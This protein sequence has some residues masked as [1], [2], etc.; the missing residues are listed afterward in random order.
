MNRDL[1]VAAL[2]RTKPSAS[3]P[4][5]LVGALVAGLLV[6]AT[7]APPALAQSAP[8]AGEYV[9][10][11]P[12]RLLDSRAAG[13]GGA[14]AALTSRDIQVTG[15]GGVPTT[16]VL[17]VVVNLAAFNNTADGWGL[18]WPT[19]ATRPN[20]ASNI[21]YIAGR[22]VNNAATVKLG[23][24]GKI[25]YYT[26]VATDVTVDVVGYYRSSPGAGGYVGVT[27]TRVL[28]TRYTGV[29]IAAG[30]TLDRKLRGVAA[31][32]DSAA[33]TAVALNMS[34][35]SQEAPGWVTVF[36]RGQAL[37]NTS[38]MNFV[39]GRIQTQLV[40]ATLS[41]DG[42]ASFYAAA[43]TDMV[44][45]V[46]GYYIEGSGA[47]F[48]PLTPTRIVDTRYG[49][50]GWGI[51]PITAALAPNTNTAIKLTGMGGVPE[52]GV[53]TVVINA[54]ADT[55]GSTIGQLSF[56]AS[57]DVQPT[58]T[59]SLTYYPNE[60]T[61]N[62][63]MAKV[64]S[65][66]KAVITN[67]AGTTAL[68]LDVVGYF[69]TESGPTTT[70]TVAPTTTTST[71]LPATV[72]AAPPSQPVIGPASSS[73]GS[74]S[75]EWSPPSQLNGS[76]ITGY[77]V[78]A[79]P[80]IGDGVQR[81]V[82]LAD[83]SA[84]SV[85]IMGVTNGTTYRVT[86]TATSN[87]GN[88]LPSEPSNATTPKSTPD[89]PAVS[90]RVSD[91]AQ[92][93]VTWLVPNDNGSRI[94]GYRVE[95]APPLPSGPITI[96]GGDNTSTTIGGLTNGT[97]YTF[98]VLAT[99]DLGDGPPGTS[100]PLWALANLAGGAKVDAF[101]GIAPPGETSALYPCLTESNRLNCR[102]SDALNT[103]FPAASVRY[104]GYYEP[105]AVSGGGNY[106]VYVADDLYEGCS[107]SEVSDE[108]RCTNHPS[109]YRFYQQSSSP[110]LVFGPALTWATNQAKVVVCVDGFISAFKTQDSSYI[111]NNC[112]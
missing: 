4:L 31:I 89:S 28:D 86:V 63:V 65:D 83:P 99:S 70:T 1:A 6:L 23:T 102:R 12:A 52:T 67:Y 109:N 79:S 105:G 29:K 44:L 45:D 55:S 25:S 19:G 46:V 92:A 42:W 47:R 24:A 53:G 68:I 20:P 62:L 22:A 69:G 77:I 36:P 50:P 30:T 71:T 13:S 112:T 49:E 104:V 98:D 40:L 66:G 35:F 39:A 11:S 97:R 17:A 82:S 110:G 103:S 33:V 7:P 74:V 3:L 81:T 32:P 95:A 93:T 43:A 18:V 85:I 37:P 26:L 80:F 90:A 94:T 2:R 84:R 51:G 54:V 88:S 106:L 76:T 9:P 10:L 5:L 48:V 78:T 111:V 56:W 60:D 8:A 73:S 108:W 14:L 75:V 58:G 27:Q 96:I 21:N 16:D 34:T 91:S 59:V 57:G 107:Y 87:R 72:P 100:N 15:Q 64:G 101:P 41:A 38:S 61:A